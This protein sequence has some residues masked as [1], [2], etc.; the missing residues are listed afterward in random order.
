M[1]R[2]FVDV[3]IYTSRNILNEGNIGYQFWFKKTHKRKI[4]SL[5][6]ND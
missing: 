5:R 4:G 1:K 6:N 2:A 3:D